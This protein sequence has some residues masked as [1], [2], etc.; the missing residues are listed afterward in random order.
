MN[1]QAINEYEIDE[2]KPITFAPREWK[3]FKLEIEN[4]IAE[5]NGLDLLKALHN[6]RYFAKLERS[7]EQFKEGK[8]I[9]FTDKEWEDFVNAQNLH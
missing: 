7:D 5:G 6:A 1:T 8:V 4:Q 9:T 3:F 2:G